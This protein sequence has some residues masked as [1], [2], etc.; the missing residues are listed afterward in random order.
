MNAI[1][2]LHVCFDL[3]C[4]ERITQYTMMK[5]P[6]MVQAWQQIRENFK[7]KKKMPVNSWAGDLFA[8]IFTE[9]NISADYN[10][11]RAEYFND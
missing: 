5:N 11:V 2:T 7:H 3:V 1:R 9:L 6:D 8:K 10:I 4:R